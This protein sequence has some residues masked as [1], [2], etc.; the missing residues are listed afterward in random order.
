VLV[1]SGI[2]LEVCGIGREVHIEDGSIVFLPFTPE[3]IRSAAI[4]VHLV[5]GGAQGKAVT[6]GGEFHFTDPMA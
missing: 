1:V 4:D 3:G 6:I 2:T 5:V